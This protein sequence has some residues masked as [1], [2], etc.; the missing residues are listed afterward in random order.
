MITTPSAQ[1]FGTMLEKLRLRLKLHPTVGTADVLKD[2]LTQANEYVYGEL[3]QGIPYE[4]QITAYPNTQS[5]CFETDDGMQVAAGSVLDVWAGQGSQLREPLTQGITHGMR[6]LQET[7]YPTHYDTHYERNQSTDVYMLE[8][9]PVPN[10]TYTIYVRHNRMLAR[11]EQPSDKPSA[12]YRLVLEKAIV[13]AKAHYQ[14]PDAQ[15]AQQDFMRMLNKEKFNRLE[16]RRFVP[17]QTNGMR[18]PQLIAAGN[19]Q[20]VVVR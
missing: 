4:S 3:E 7:G 20:F 9:W 16:N 2:L 14:Q 5:M 8:L 18:Q 1:N 15:V 10:G 11:F 19:G 12:P 17:A 13:T 6:S